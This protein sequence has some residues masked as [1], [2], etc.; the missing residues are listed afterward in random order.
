MRGHICKYPFEKRV[1]LPSAQNE[2]IISLEKP[3]TIDARMVY[4]NSAQNEII[5]RTDHILSTQY[6][7]KTTC[8]IVLRRP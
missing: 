8:Y 7:T 2:I 6:E 4:L 5:I 1:G 3:D